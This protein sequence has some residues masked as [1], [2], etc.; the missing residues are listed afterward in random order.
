MG[1]RGIILAVIGFIIIVVV[2]VVIALIP[3]ATL[4]FSIAP[5]EATVSIN[6]KEQSIKNQQSIT[7]APGEIKIIISRDEF[8]PYQETVTVKNGDT[9]EVI[10]ALDPKTDAANRLME[11]PEALEVLQRVTSKSIQTVTNEQAKKYPLMNE[12]PINDKFYSIIVC[13][14]EKYPNDTSKIAI[15]IKLYDPE[16]KQSAYDEI[17]SRGY[18][19][20]DYEIII[21]DSSYQVESQD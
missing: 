16:A 10:G 15:C 13:G 4:K 19:L 7:V 21:V 11:T 14:S 6:G 1:R 8:G 20:E 2:I 5:T 12:L 18:K 3:K 9:Y 17:T